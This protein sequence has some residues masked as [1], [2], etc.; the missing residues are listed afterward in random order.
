[1]YFR[2]SPGLGQARAEYLMDGWR[3]T[4]PRGTHPP[5]CGR[6]ERSGSYL[7]VKGD[8]PGLAR[9]S[10]PTFSISFGFIYS[11]PAPES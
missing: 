10:F 6:D 9:D 4:A 1:M 11:F 3:C 7:V 8:R 2:I 5:L